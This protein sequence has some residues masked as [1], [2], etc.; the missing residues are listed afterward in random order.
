M[1]TEQLKVLADLTE[2]NRHGEARWYIADKFEYC[3]DLKQQFNLINKL[4]EI[5]GHLDYFLGQ[6]RSEKVKD[7]MER[8]ERHEGIK[9]AVAINRCL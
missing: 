3:S 1:D 4:A 6:Y 5:D 7:L 9:V 8:I 2:N